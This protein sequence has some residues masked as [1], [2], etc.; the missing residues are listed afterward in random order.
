[1]T[2]SINNKLYLDRDKNIGNTDG[3]DGKGRAHV[4]I[5]NK[6]TEPVPVIQQTLTGVPKRFR[7]AGSTTPGTEQTL[8][9]ETV[10]A[11]KTWNVILAG[12]L[13]RMTGRWRL[14]VDGTLEGS[15]YTGPG[16]NNELFDYRGGVLEA[17]ATKVVEVKF[18]ARSGSATGSNVDAYLHI[19]EE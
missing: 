14:L 11:G 12:A 13:T 5:S 19:T 15:G 18:L 9:S 17:A 10:P 8:I 1:M 16:G 2:G 6:I 3:T 7:L 4:K